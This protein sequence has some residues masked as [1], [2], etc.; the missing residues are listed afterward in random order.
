VTGGTELDRLVA[1]SRAL[2]ADPSL[3]VHGGG[4]TSTK[5]EERDHRGRLREV[6]RIKGSGTDLATIGP[7]GFPGL[8]LDDLLAL[9]ERDAMPDEEMVGYLA[10]CMLDPSARRPSI[11]TLL[12]AFLPARHIDHTH[13]DAICTLTNHPEGR[14]AVREALGDEVAV[15]SYLRPGFGLSKR[16]AE[17][18][19]AQ[20]AVLQY[21]GLV[22][23]G[24]THDASLEA[25]R[26]LAARAEAYLAA[27]RRPPGASAP[28]LPEDEAARILVALRDALSAD[29]R[30]VLHVD[31][32]GG[33]R[34]ADRPDVDAVAAGRSTPDHMLRIGT[35]SAVVRASSE[36][37]AVVG[38]FA[39]ENRAYV[40]RHA[41]R[42]PAGIGPLSPLPRV[43]LVPGLG[44]VAAGPDPRAARVNADIAYRSH[45]VTADVL[46]V[47]GRVAWLDEDEIF[48]FDYWPLELYKLTLAPK[49]PSLAGRV[50]IAAGVPA[51]LAAP[52]AAAGAVLVE[53]SA[54]DAGGAM[55]RAVDL[56]GGVDAVVAGSDALAAAA[57]AGAS[58]LPST[59]CLDVVVVASAA[60][61]GSAGAWRA[62]PDRAIRSFLVRG[63]DAAAAGEAV[64]FVL[65]GRAPLQPSSVLQL[66]GA[67]DA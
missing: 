2:G 63:D 66:A 16:T 53:A 17:Q 43:V 25:T 44:L 46:D 6:M 42:L 47:F 50:V 10:H 32:D 14:A 27:R 4:N 3:V 54:S 31:R 20:A 40:E 35:R 21:H 39:D 28:V 13:A 15:V 7:D 33:R 26:A 18:A 34:L 56:H 64:A 11:E 1:R 57:I 5:L 30:R 8:F 61:N 9:R 41:A 45:L 62:P 60:V 49:P 51:E 37:D 36:V 19:D 12:H 52:L 65:A 22:T 48:D 58:G 67:R 23:W 29:G 24:E 38:A 55:G 59:R